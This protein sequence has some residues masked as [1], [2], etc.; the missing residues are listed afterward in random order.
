MKGSLKELA[1][2][3]LVAFVLYVGNAVAQGS[4]DA[5]NFY[6]LPPSNP[7]SEWIWGSPYLVY[8]QGGSLRQVKLDIDPKHCGWYTKM[9]FPDPVPDSDIS[10]IWLNQTPDDQIGLLG[11]DEDTDAWVDGIPTPFNLKER[12]NTVVGNNKPGD[13]F[14]APADFTNIWSTTDHGR[15]G[16]C[17]SA[18]IVKN[19]L[20]V[21]DQNQ[22]SSG[23]AQV[24]IESNDSGGQGDEKCGKDMG[25]ILNYYLLNR[26]GDRLELNTSNNNCKLI[27]GNLVC[28]GGITLTNWPAVDRIKMSVP[29]TYGL[30]GTQ[31]IY[32]RIKDSESANYPNAN[33]VQIVVFSVGTTTKPVWGQINTDG[34][35]PIYNLGDKDKNVVS[36]KLVPIGFAAGN[37]LCDN[38][39]NYGKSNCPFEVFMAPAAEGG[40]FGQRVNV[41]VQVTPGAK[42]SGL[43]FYRD[44]LGNERVE[45][46]TTFEVPSTGKFAG[47]LVLWVKG[48]YDAQEDE[49]YT[50]NTDLGVKVWLPRLAFIDPQT[51]TR[52]AQ[53]KGS[54]PSLSNNVRDMGVMVGTNLERAIAAYDISNGSPVLCTTCNF[55][56]N[57]KAW[58]ED[59]QRNRLD[60]NPSFGTDRNLIQSSPAYIILTGGVA[61]FSIRGMKQVQAD[62]F[63]F[64]TVHGLS[65]KPETFAQWDSLLF[66]LRE[67]PIP[68]LAE[69]YDRNGDGIGDSL[70]IVYSSRFHTD[71]LPSKL[72]VTWDPDTTFEFGLG[73]KEGDMYSG[74]NISPAANR[75]YWNSDHP[76][77]KTK[78]EGGPGQMS[79]YSDSVIVIYGIDF[80]K[81]IKT[82]LAPN[83]V[84]SWATYIDSK[85]GMII[86]VSIPVNIDAK[87]TTPIRPPQ[88]SSANSA[89]TT[90]NAI[91]L[92]AQNSGRLEIYNLDGKLAK[93]LNFTNGTHSVPLSHLPKGMYIIKVSFDEDA[94]LL[95]P[96][97]LRTLVM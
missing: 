51:N 75:T 74:K 45:G 48:D 8:M 50:I 65:E 5:Y 82:S 41:S 89:F 23:G 67:Y 38:P 37:W 15:E 9:F 93:T 66:K 2:A 84:V 79:G 78:L 73:T 85:R 81:R 46:S 72:L 26:R 92:Q 87:G 1:L 31:K 70:R 62:T 64:F 29:N 88:I 49:T 7:E 97:I 83:E 40:S 3:F 33:P 77:F 55:P 57:I 27:G 42:Y 43:T 36:G 22:I 18:V 32:A 52:L 96:I 20:S 28:Y 13:L 11:L 69:I 90:Q 94:N 76:N 4:Y 17:S 53:T 68:M 6:F 39:D 44:S 47:L 60:N 95:S 12:F 30:I 61:E 16:V 80:S 10:L 35:N 86:N 91:H 56:L 34:G 59:T 71:S 63:A 24:C 58:A 19:S 14:F 25:D 21:K 54:N